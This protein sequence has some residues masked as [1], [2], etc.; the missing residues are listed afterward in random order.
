M[1]SGSSSKNTRSSS[2]SSSST[3]H[4]RRTSTQQ[5]GLSSSAGSGP[6]KTRQA[7]LDEDAWKLDESDDEQES[8][9]TRGSE[10][11]KV[12][13]QAGLGRKA[14]ASSFGGLQ[15]P[16]R[17]ATASQTSLSSMTSNG[18]TSASNTRTPSIASPGPSTSSA[19][20]KSPPPQA[21]FKER[22]RQSSYG[23]W[24]RISGF[25]SSKGSDKERE[26]AES[27][28]DT[29]GYAR[30]DGDLELEDNFDGTYSINTASSSSNAAGLMAPAT[31]SRALSSGKVPETQL[32]S[33][34]NAQKG[35]NRSTDSPS[36]NTTA[37]IVG[38]PRTRSPLGR[39]RG[40]DRPRNSEDMRKYVRKD[41][42]DVMKGVLPCWAYRAS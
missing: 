15:A 39:L 13:A 23:F 10:I 19:G 31:I 7:T 2:S 5:S 33:S 40:G 29:S 36:G 24:E 22:G 17:A 41:L 21:A 42:E 30:F 16:P 28:V 38:T 11:A 3:A 12:A 6:N 1:W 32:P 37:T 18:S 34:A 9:H 25:G 26:R 4:H 8:N 20:L 27:P 14:S 35:K